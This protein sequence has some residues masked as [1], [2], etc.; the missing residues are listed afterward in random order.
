MTA[1]IKKLSWQLLHNR[2]RKKSLQ[3]GVGAN[4]FFSA[5]ASAMPGQ[6][7]IIVWPM[8]LF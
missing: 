7:Q 6:K 3:R 5:P 8:A 1:K 4:G 2:H